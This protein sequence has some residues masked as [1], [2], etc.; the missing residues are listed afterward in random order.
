MN[1]AYAKIGQRVKSFR[2]ERGFSQDELAEGICSR[3][4]ISLL[5]NGQH[6]PSA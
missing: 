1:E 2:K 4:T 5:E 6:F 3:Q